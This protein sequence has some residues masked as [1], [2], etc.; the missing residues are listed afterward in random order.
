MLHSG[1]N[2]FAF[3]KAQ[4]YSGESAVQCNSSYIK[5]NKA[6]TEQKRNSL[7]SPNN[8]STPKFGQ[9]TFGSQ[10]SVPNTGIT[11][12]FPAPDIAE[13]QKKDSNNEGSDPT[14][15]QEIDVTEFDLASDSTMKSKWGSPQRQARI[16]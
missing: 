1:E 8:S 11:K 10:L 4:Q 13:K 16:T 6:L 3:D 12:E 7:G 2:L 5:C 15:E 14:L 9:A